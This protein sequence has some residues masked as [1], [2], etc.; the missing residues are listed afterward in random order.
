MEGHEPDRRRTDGATA[1][2]LKRLARFI[3]SGAPLDLK[4]NGRRVTLP[5]DANLSIDL[6]RDP[7]SGCVEVDIRWSLPANAGAASISAK[8][9]GAQ[10]Q[11]VDGRLTQ[12]RRQT[13]PRIRLKALVSAPTI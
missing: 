10:E 4:L 3:D 13:G 6:D 11:A 5:A 2:N 7:R 9:D 12:A 8:R 1:E